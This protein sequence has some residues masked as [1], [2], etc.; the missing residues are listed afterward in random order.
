ME[1]LRRLE[2]VIE[3]LQADLVTKS[4]Q[5]MAL[6]DGAQRDVSQQ[7]SEGEK[8]PDSSKAGQTQARGVSSLD[9]EFGKLAVREGRSRYVTENFWA[10]LSDEVS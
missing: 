8:S 7:R 10:T 3:N 4:D 1:R 5:L 6:G 2:S 9:A